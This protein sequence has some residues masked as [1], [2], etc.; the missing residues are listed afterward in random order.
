MPGEVIKKKASKTHSSHREHESPKRIPQPRRQV[1]EAPKRIPQP[2]RQVHEAPKRIPQPSRHEAPKRI[3]QPSRQEHKPTKQRTR[4]GYPAHEFEKKNYQKPYRC[5]GCKEL[6]YGSRYKRDNVELHRE[7]LFPS[8]TTS[9]EFF[10]GDTFKFLK[11]T[12][13]EKERCCDACG[14]DVKGFV[15]HC[16]AKEWD[17]H[18][19][20]RK[21][22]NKMEID[23]VKFQLCCNKVPKKKCLFCKKEKLPNGV[24]GIPGWFYRSAGNDNYHFHVNCSMKWVIDSWKDIE[25]QDNNRLTLNNLALTELKADSI[26]R[27]R[28]VLKYLRIAMLVLRCTASLLL[29]DPTQLL[30]SLPDLLSSLG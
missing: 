10:P 3:P 11:K 19:C 1:H 24:P 23:G 18:P 17:L 9:H 6:G 27:D 29:G 8:R 20:C 30:F 21:L 2:S 25:Q 16:E 7:C 28:K 14:M 12:P 13:G 26:K 4:S 15:Y 22:K 5:D